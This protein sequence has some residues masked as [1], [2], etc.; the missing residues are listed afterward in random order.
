MRG[1]GAARGQCSGLE[2]RGIEGLVPGLRWASGLPSCVMG[3]WRGR[4]QVSRPQA[5]R[6][7]GQPGRG[8]TLPLLTGGLNAPA[9][10]GWGI[11]P[12]LVAARQGPQGCIRARGY[13]SGTREGAGVPLRAH[14]RAAQGLAALPC[15]SPPRLCLAAGRGGRAPRADRARLSV[16]TTQPPATLCW[17]SLVFVWRGRR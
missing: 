4:G 9:G 11:Q 6:A 12:G 3:T 2:G 13:V 14:R 10:L 17:A 8:S 16:W 7:M 15:P 1:L 5:S